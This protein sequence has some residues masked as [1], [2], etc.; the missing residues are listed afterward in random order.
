MAGTG[1]T[2]NILIDIEPAA[3]EAA[4][5]HELLLALRRRHDLARFEFTSRVRIVPTAATCTNY[6]DDP[7][8][9]PVITLGTRF[10]ETPDVLLSTYLHEQMHC[11]LWRLGGRPPGVIALVM[12]ELVRRYPKAPVTLPEGARSYEETYEH[13]IVCWLELAATGELIG[14]ARAAAIADTQWGY[15]WIYRTVIADFEPLGALCRQFGLYPIRS[16]AAMA[17]ADQQDARRTS[18]ARQRTARVA[19]RTPLRKAPRKSPARGGRSR[20]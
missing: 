5:L 17:R 13:L 8:A 3:R 15:R 1:D 11:Y 12:D 18:G 16:L 14:G 6:P 2:F 19:P 4:R 10:A 20:G 9:D 7:A